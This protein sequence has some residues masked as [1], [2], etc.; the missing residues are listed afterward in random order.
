[1]RLLEQ[2]GWLK[3]TFM[4]L[5][6]FAHLAFFGFSEVVIRD[7]NQL[8]PEVITEFPELLLEIAI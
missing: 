7:K 3:Y 2:A 4:L 6:R 1:M 5:V 8:V